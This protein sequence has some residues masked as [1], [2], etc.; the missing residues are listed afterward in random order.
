MGWD[1]MHWGGWFL[2]LVVWNNY[3][4]VE[5]AVIMKWLSN[6]TKKDNNSHS[7][8]LRQGPKIDIFDETSLCW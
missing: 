8:S 3:L 5:P 7:P 6:I 1:G 2:F 4:Y